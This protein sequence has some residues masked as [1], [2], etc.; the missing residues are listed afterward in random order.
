MR[1]GGA[2][3]S[4]VKDT[5][6]VFAATTGGIYDAD[7]AVA[8]TGSIDFATWCRTV[9]KPRAMAHPAWSGRG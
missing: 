4:A 9:L 5:S 8:P 7:W 1:A 6:E 3:E 2:S